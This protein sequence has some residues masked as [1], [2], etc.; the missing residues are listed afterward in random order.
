MSNYQFQPLVDPTA[1]GGGGGGAVPLS[2]QILTASTENGIDFGANDYPC[3]GIQCGDV[4]HLGGRISVQIE[5]ASSPGAARWLICD[6]PGVNAGGTSFG[7]C[8]FNTGTG[9]SFPGYCVCIY[10]AIQF[11]LLDPLGVVPLGF[12]DIV[13]ETTYTATV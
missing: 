4:V 8:V 7:A 5:P 9:G 12:A 13:F 10:D 6:V 3:R 1:S 11:I 2:I